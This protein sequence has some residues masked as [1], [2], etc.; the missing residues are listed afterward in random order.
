MT[1]EWV[2]FGGNWGEQW[3]KQVS[4]DFM[5]AICRVSRLMTVAPVPVPRAQQ[6]VP[7]AIQPSQPLAAAVPVEHSSQLVAQPLD[8]AIPPIMPLPP[9]LP[10]REEHSRQPL[11]ALPLLPMPL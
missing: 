6:W 10:P 11:A 5:L 3:K 7:K 4:I 9:A 1:E 8:A 2:K